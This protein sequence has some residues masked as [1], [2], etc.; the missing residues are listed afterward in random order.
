MKLDDDD[1]VGLKVA[2]QARIAK[3]TK[4]QGLLEELEQ[5]E[6]DLVP[7]RHGRRWGRKGK[8][9]YKIKCARCGEIRTMKLP[10]AKYCSD[11]CR[12]VFWEEVRLGK[13]ERPTL[14]EEKI[15]VSNP[16]QSKKPATLLHGDPIRA[17]EGSR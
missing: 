13:R 4:I 12:Q 11:R 14:G 6:G 3:L 5:E 10:N 1:L 7:Q 8:P 9:K 16:V 15:Y 2:L 17:G